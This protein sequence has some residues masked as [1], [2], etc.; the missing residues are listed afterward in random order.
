MD[1]LGIHAWDIDVSQAY[2]GVIIVGLI[3]LSPC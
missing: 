2:G 3:I 1:R